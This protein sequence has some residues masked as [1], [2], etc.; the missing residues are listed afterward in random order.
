ML[1][2]VQMGCVAL[3]SAKTGAGVTVTGS[4]PFRFIIIL[5]SPPQTAEA[6]TGLMFTDEADDYGCGWS[7]SAEESRRS[8]RWLWALEFSR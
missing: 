2:P 8:S 4:M 6:A 3:M 5:P 7:R 1:L